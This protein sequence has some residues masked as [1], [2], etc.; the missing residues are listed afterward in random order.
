MPGPRRRVQGRCSL[1]SSPSSGWCPVVPSV[2]LAVT[3]SGSRPCPGHGHGPY[4]VDARRTHRATVRDR[5]E[6][7]VLPEG[8]AVTRRRPSVRL[9]TGPETVVSR[10][11]RAARS[12]RPDR[13]GALVTQR[14]YARRR[15]VSQTAVWKRPSARVAGPDPRAEEEDRPDRGRSSVGGIPVPSGPRTRKPP[16][17]GGAHHPRRVWRAPARPSPR[18]RLRGGRPDQ[19][20]D[21]RTTPGRARLP[22]SATAK[23]FGFAR[24]IRDTWLAWP[25]RVGPLLAATYDLDAGSVTVALEGYVREQLEDLAN[26]RCEF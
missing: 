10:L 21:P 2:V 7:R 15:G 16:A 14:A 22:S 23:A 9:V 8:G 12:A 24:M 19:A 25:A 26:E 4:V 11:S 13:V 20:V 17:H 3:L 18:R 1:N 6:A 5:A